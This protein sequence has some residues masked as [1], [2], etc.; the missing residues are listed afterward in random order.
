MTIFLTGIY[1]ALMWKLEPSSQWGKDAKF[2]EKKRPNEMA[3]VLRNV[4]RFVKLLNVSRNSKSAQAGYLHKEPHGVVAVDQK[5]GG[6]NLQEFRLYTLPVDQTKTLHL[7]TIGTKD[8]QH[9]DIEY[10]K[11]FADCF[12]ETT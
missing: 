11:T 8:T 9:S 7:I 5:G 6:P 12:T 1:S 4:E 2:Y 10:S 3:A